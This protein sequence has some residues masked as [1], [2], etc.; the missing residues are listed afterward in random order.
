MFNSKKYIYIYI[1][2]IIF[3]YIYKYAVCY[4][5]LGLSFFVLSIPVLYV[6]FVY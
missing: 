6:G 4:I 1:I 3:I 2:Y 5:K